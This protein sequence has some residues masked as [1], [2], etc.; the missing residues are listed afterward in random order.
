MLRV[1][2]NAVIAALTGA[3]LLGSVGVATASSRAEGEATQSSGTL[4][5]NVIQVPVHVPLNFCGNSVNVLS[6]LNPTFG[7]G[8]ANVEGGVT[9]TE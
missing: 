7:N 8:C 6:L 2:R 4:S 5:G 1:I 3:S 9:G